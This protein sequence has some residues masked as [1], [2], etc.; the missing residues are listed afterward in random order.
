MS[1]KYPKSFITDVKVMYP[2]NQELHKAL[3]EGNYMVGK[4]LKDYAKQMV[5]TVN[6]NDVFIDGG[7]NFIFY[8]KKEMEKRRAIYLRWENIVQS[9]EENE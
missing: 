1:M 3:E 4:Y 6:E 9:K 5:V 2:E 8:I 7:K